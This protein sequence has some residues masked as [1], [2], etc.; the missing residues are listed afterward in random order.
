MT[1]ND[2]LRRLRYTFNYKDAA[3]VN[4]LA[5][6]NL[7]V[8]QQV[9]RN[10]LKKDEDEGFVEMQDVELA[11]FLNGLINEKRGKREGKQ[12]APETELNN[13]L[14]LIKLR[15]AMNWQYEDIVE[16]LLLTGIKFST[17]EVSAFFRKPGTK[18][19]RW[20]KDQFLRKLL[21]GM[22]KRYRTLE[23]GE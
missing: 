5:S 23:E 21:I 4:I 22:Q 11:S 14:V 18:K 6:A 2:I 3:M 8:D 1:N 19:F 17:T 15:I 13:N 9:I 20:C 7:T 10:W 12:P 16:T